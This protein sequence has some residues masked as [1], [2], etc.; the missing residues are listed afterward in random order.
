MLTPAEWAMAAACVEA[1]AADELRWADQHKY[2]R[3]VR[4]LEQQRYHTNKADEL[5]KLA[6]KLREQV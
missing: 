1:R 2:G 4:D 6:A 3:T 5:T